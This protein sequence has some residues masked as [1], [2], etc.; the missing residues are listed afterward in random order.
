MDIKPAPPGYIRILFIT[1]N[2][3]LVHRIDGP[4]VIYYDGHKRYYIESKE[5]SEA[6]FLALTKIEN[7]EDQQL[8]IDLT[9][10]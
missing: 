6:E 5:L 4:A 7:K 2:F 3:K 8:G 1:P 9:E 10:I